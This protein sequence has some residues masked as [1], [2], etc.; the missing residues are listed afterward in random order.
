[1]FAAHLTQSCP[2]LLRGLLRE[3]TRVAAINVE[4]VTRETTREECSPVNMGCVACMNFGPPHSFCAYRFE[5]GKARLMLEHASQYMAGKYCDGVRL[6]VDNAD[7]VMRMMY[8][9]MGNEGN[10]MEFSGA[11]YLSYLWDTYNNKAILLLLEEDPQRRAQV[12]PQFVPG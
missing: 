12:R 11:R 1:M 3:A 9:A 8:T 4:L 5:L 2:L 6:A 7:T 10:V